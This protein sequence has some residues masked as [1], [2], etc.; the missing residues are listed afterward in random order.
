[1]VVHPYTPSTQK[2]RQWGHWRLKG[3]M[4]TVK[5][6]LQKEKESKESL[7]AKGGHPDNNMD[8]IYLS[9]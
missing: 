5:L 7:Q 9:H 2:V 8:P 3:T 1:M 6:S 4:W